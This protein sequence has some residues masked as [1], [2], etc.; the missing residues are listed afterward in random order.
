M[1]TAATLRSFQNEIEE[2][3]KQ[4]LAKKRAVPI[5]EKENR[6]PANDSPPEII[7]EKQATV[8]DLVDESELQVN[9]SVFDIG[10]LKLKKN[11]SETIAI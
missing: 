8:D 6:D 2:L 10:T 1:A 9:T 11:I 3:Q 4:G 7:A 5:S